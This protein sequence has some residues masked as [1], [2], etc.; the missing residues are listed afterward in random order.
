MP[1][2]GILNWTIVLGREQGPACICKEI[3]KYLCEKRMEYTYKRGVKEIGVTYMTM[4]K[5]IQHTI[6]DM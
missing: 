3:Q 6:Y 2:D 1:H 5:E 4:S